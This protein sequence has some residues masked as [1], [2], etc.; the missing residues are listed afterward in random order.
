MCFSKHL[1]KIS[2]SFKCVL[3]LLHTYMHH[4][5]FLVS[6]CFSILKRKWCCFSHHT[7]PPTQLTL[8]HPIPPYSR[9]NLPVCTPRISG[10]QIWAH[11][12]IQLF[13]ID[14][15]D[16]ICFCMFF[17]SNWNIL[18]E[19]MF[20]HRN[21]WKSMFFC[22]IIENDKILYINMWKVRKWWMLRI[23]GP[24]ARIARTK[25]E[26]LERRHERKALVLKVFLAPPHSCS[27]VLERGRAQA[28]GLDPG[29][30]A[31]LSFCNFLLIFMFFHYIYWFLMKF[32]RNDGFPKNI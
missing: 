10:G 11:L 27:N 9:R 25:S 29:I 2:E 15:Y 5:Y 13:F 7:P 12:W 19:I 16:F 21:I 30:G 17:V 28:S 6:F 1:A 8:L 23:L 14:L 3:H 24:A 18:I 31:Y 32:V 20:F 26:L 4:A 22:K